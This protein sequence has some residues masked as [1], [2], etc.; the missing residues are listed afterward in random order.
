MTGT[1]I[2]LS[3]PGHPRERTTCFNR[4]MLGASSI[5]WSALGYSRRSSGFAT[6]SSGPGDVTMDPLNP[7]V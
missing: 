7:R 2:D 5:L 1:I 3:E 6:R 4:E